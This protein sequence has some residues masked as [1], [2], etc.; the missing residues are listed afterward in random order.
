MPTVSS[1]ASAKFNGILS[2]HAFPTHSDLRRQWPV[3][4]RRDHFTITSHTRVCCRHFASDQLIETERRPELV[5][6]DDQEEQTSVERRHGL[7]APEALGQDYIERG[8]VSASSPF[9]LLAA[10]LHRLQLVQNA[11]ARLLT[12]TGRFASITPVLADLHW[13]PI[14]FKILPLTFKIMN[15]AAPSYL[16]ELL[17]PYTPGRALRS[18]DQLLLVQPR[19]RHK[20][21]GD[22]AF[23]LVAPNLWNN[24]PIAI[25]ASDSI[26]L[27]KSR[28]KTHLFNLSFPVG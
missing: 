27:F 6:P 21:R 16:A 26:Q 23:A 14:K 28:L 8:S 17:R 24:L 4:I 10:L 22:R 3:N 9:P 5:P 7:T 12:G 13:L 1:S 18:S 19:S 25:R 15:N 20:S 11:A 2:F